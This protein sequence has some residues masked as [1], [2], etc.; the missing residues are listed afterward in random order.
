MC[1]IYLLL[2][3]IIYI[4]KQKN[5]KMLEKKCWFYKITFY[6]IKENVLCLLVMVEMIE[7]GV[8]GHGL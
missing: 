1:I 7:Y 4:F 8:G 6:L 5:S 3:I 2:N